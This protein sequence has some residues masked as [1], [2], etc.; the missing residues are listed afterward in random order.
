MAATAIPS[1]GLYRLLKGMESRKVTGLLHLDTARGRVTLGIRKGRLVQVET[2]VPELGFGAFLV[3]A[4]M[5]HDPASAERL[6]STR[7]LVDAGVL[8]PEDA[9]KLHGSYARSLLARILDAPVHHWSFEAREALEGVV[10]DMPVDP[11]PELLRALSQVPN[12]DPLRQ[13][14]RRL[15]QAGGLSLAPGSEFL[16]SHVRAHFGATPL[17]ALLREGRVGE[18][19][20]ASLEDPDAVRILFALVVAGH[21]QSS[22]AS[23]P[24]EKGASSPVPQAPPEEALE[25][26]RVEMRKPPEGPALGDGRR[27]RPSWIEPADPVHM[28]TVSNP[29]EKEIASAWAEMQRQTFYETLGVTSDA[30]LS[31]V[32]AGWL[33]GRGHFALARYQDVL[34]PDSLGLLRRIHDH[35]DTA[36]EVLFDASRRTAY[37]RRI[38]LSTPSL[39]AT[40]Q[41]IFEARDPHRK[42]LEDLAARRFPEA[43]EHFRDAESLD[44]E[45]PEYVAAQ[46]RVFLSMPPS[47]ENQRQARALLE[48]A[49]SGNPDLVDALVALAGLARIEGKTD[50]AR[51]LLRRALALDGDHE[52]ALALRALL[53]PRAAAP[54]MQFARKGSSWW[55][56]LKELWRRKK[57]P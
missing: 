3:K 4:R 5:V 39:E 7:R 26:A 56:R 51:D 53:K 28:A 1:W 19:G 18:I 54:K 8:R 40:V 43:L 47:P 25:V 37:N 30:R 20:E 14:V 46:G 13:A 49:L 36:K 22:G 55:E 45:E 15:V 12:P 16:L 24:G 50:E 2:E 6:A 21:L 33:K 27:K 48:R 31:F 42:G 29:F 38:E 10:S 34:S 57:G 35:L 23:K 11:F 41:K 9:A 52:E 32:Q 44:P 17:V